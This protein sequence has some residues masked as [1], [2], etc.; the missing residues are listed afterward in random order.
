MCFMFSYRRLDMHNDDHYHNHHHYNHGH[1]RHIS[2]I[3]RQ[4]SARRTG[5]GTDKVADFSK[6]SNR[7]PANYVI[8]R[9][10]SYFWL[11]NKAILSAAHMS[12][13]YPANMMNEVAKVVL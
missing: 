5:C 11:I 13:L 4:P 6:D 12:S 9:K 3:P 2:S 10:L 8:I 1:H 7:N